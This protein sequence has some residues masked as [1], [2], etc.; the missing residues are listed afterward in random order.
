[1]LWTLEQVLKSSATFLFAAIKF[2]TYEQLSR[3]I[4]H[5][6][7]DTGGDGQLTPVLRLSAGAGAALARESP[8]CC[9]ALAVVPPASNYSSVWLCVWFTLHSSVMLAPPGCAAR[10]RQRHT[11]L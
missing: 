4:S 8:R 11:L 7:I 2:M 1:M 5:H 9:A 10:T 3:K 6:L